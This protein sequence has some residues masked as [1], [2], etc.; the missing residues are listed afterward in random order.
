M[1]PARMRSTV[2]LP[3]PEG[4]RSATTSL[5]AIWIEMSSSTRNGL[6]L[7]MMKSCE[8]LR[9]SHRISRACDLALAAPARCALISFAQGEA[10]FG[11]AVTP[12]PH[13]SIEGDDQQRHDQDR[14]RQM[15]EVGARG[16]VAD[17]RAEARGTQ[18]MSL[19]GHV[20]GHDARV[21]GASRRRHPSRDEVG[22]YG[23]E[24]E[25]AKAGP[26]RDAIAARGFL[27][28]RRNHHR[29]RNDV[30]QN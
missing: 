19:E 1:R 4:P 30:E 9:T 6:P 28:V 20:F 18:R 16:G 21:P 5:R 27:Q 8:T 3:E 29:A 23:G 12:P 25:C 2:D 11:E 22:K 24:I 14:G 13:G 7:G 26:A 17:L 10:F 15:R